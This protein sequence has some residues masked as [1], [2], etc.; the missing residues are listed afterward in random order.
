M[1]SVQQW[2]PPPTS[3]WLHVLTD[4]F[5]LDGI[6]WQPKYNPTPLLSCHKAIHW[7]PTPNVFFGPDFVNAFGFDLNSWVG[8][9]FLVQCFP[10]PPPPYFLSFLLTFFLYCKLSHLVIVCCWCLPFCKFN[11]AWRCAIWFGWV[12]AVPRVELTNMFVQDRLHKPT[13]QQLVWCAGNRTYRTR[14]MCMLCQQQLQV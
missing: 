10:P 5:A 7:S 8:I 14:L 1:K 2:R 13:N 11:A 4:Y 6:F 9:G 3:H 12:N